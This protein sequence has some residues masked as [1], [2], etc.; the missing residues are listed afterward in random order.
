MASRCLAEF[1]DGNETPEAD[2]GGMLIAEGML[3]SIALAG[4]FDKGKVRKR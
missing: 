2:A 1:R 4:G 3:A